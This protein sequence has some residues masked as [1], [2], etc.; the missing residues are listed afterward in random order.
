[1][2]LVANKNEDN[3]KATYKEK[4]VTIYREMPTSMF[5]FVNFWFQI[6]NI[7]KEKKRIFFIW[8]VFWLVVFVCLILIL[9]LRFFSA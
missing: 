6:S 3:K 1:M 2:Y 7:Q 8:L 4:P 9:F 5:N